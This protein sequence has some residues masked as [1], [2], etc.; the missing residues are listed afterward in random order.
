MQRD[1]I[2]QLEALAANARNSLANA[3]EQLRDALAA[4]LVH[5]ESSRLIRQDLDACRLQL[6]E[7]LRQLRTAINLTTTTNVN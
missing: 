3:A 1:Q 2:I 4:H 5:P 7:Q 6:D